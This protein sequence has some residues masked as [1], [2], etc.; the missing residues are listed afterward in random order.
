MA[1][2]PTNPVLSRL[3]S[4]CQSG[5]TRLA[6]QTLEDLADY[7]RTARP[8]AEER[9]GLLAEL[10]QARP[11]MVVIGNAIDRV[12]RALNRNG[13]EPWNL[14]ESVRREFE[15]TTDR[16]VEN[17]LGQIHDG[18]VIMTH[19]A[20][21]V[22]IRLFRRMVDAQIAFS[23]IC[24][25]SSPGQEGHGLASTLNELEVPV[26]LITDAQMAL[27][28]SD[29]DVVMTGCDSWL[30]DGHFVNKSGTHLL[31][32]AAYAHNVPF[33]VLADTFRDSQDTRESVHLEELPATELNAPEGK[34]ITPRNV[35][36]EPVPEQLITGR[37]SELGVSLCPVELQR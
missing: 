34:W 35:Y 16:I 28:M 36:F 15:A 23:V 32:L 24:T 29:A 5:A 18:A 25:Q 37:I 33:W 26:T 3:K 9:A 14:V 6:L 11:S 31:A 19:S 27:F 12:E 1:D 30:T 8:G 4:D 22:L 20:S 17:A 2:Q 21:S 7:L 13:D 10:R